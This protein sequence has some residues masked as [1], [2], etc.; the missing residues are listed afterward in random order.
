MS[1]YES[2]FNIPEEDTTPNEGEEIN[3]Q[4]ETETVNESDS[5]PQ[6]EEQ[7]TGNETDNAETAETS[8]EPEAPKPF[9]SIKFNHENIDMTEEE[10]RNTVQLAKKNESLLAELDYLAALNDET[11]SEFVKNL[12]KASDD[13]LLERL[14]SKYNDLNDDELKDM[15]DFQRNKNKEKYA[16]VLENR[17]KESEDAAKNAEQSL[18]ERMS[19]EL[20]EVQEVFP[21][22]KEFNDLPENVRKAALSGSDLLKEYLKHLH[23]EDLKIKQNKTAEQK[24]TN[25]ASG[26]VKSP[27]QT[28]D[29][30]ELNDF[31]KGVWGK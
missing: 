31:I 16:T 13:A 21:E 6:E 25:A 24:A 23:S 28:N 10:V 3:T 18:N 7:N 30:A 4:A 26:S 9:L 12:S 27:E 17:K 8:S 11:V 20:A 14:R 19:N 5:A 29:T 15:A 2:G 1:D 22:I